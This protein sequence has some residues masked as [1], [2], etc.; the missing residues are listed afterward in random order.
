MN[1]E[2][3]TG[4]SLVLLAGLLQGTFV[5]PMTLTRKWAWEHNWL[6]FSVLG[7]LALNWLLAGLLIPDLAAVYRATPAADLGRSSCLAL[8][9]ASAP[10]SSDWECS[11][12]A[13]HWGI[14]SSW[15]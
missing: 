12:W 11:V 4:L 1:A 13:W 14:R 10:F 15:A 6:V 5:L 2:F 3:L 9:G 7:M 8:F